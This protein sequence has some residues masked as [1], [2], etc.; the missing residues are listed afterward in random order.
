MVKRNWDIATYQFLEALPSVLVILSAI[1]YSIVTFS[2]FKCCKKTGDKFYKWT[3]SG[4]HGAAAS[5]FGGK[6]GLLREEPYHPVT[7]KDGNPISYIR[8]EKVSGCFLFLFGLFSLLLLIL[9]VTTFWDVFLFRETT[10][11]SDGL[12]CYHNRRLIQNCTDIENSGIVV[13]CYVIVL[14][15]GAAA[16]VAGGIITSGALTVSIMAGILLSLYDHVKE[17]EEEDEEKAKKCFRCIKF[18]QYSL[19]LGILIVSA[20]ILGV[21]HAL[22]YINVGQLSTFNL[23]QGF[24]FSLA[25]TFGLSFPW[26]KY[27][28]KAHHLEVPA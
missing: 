6:L 3:L 20:I 2:A 19:V 4:L 8:Q 7:D 17:I 28:Q 25:I 1:I 12:D 26:Y 22:S 27:A 5:I 23:L 24:C 13:K 11:C 14:E 16:G 21:I 9:S 10:A 18:V 15:I